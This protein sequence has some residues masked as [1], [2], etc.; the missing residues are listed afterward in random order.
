M[1]RGPYHASYQDPFRGLAVSAVTSNLIDTRAAF[2]VSLSW[3]TTSGS[4]SVNT[5]QISNAS[6]FNMSIPETTWSDWTVFGDGSIPATQPSGVSTF[7]PPLGYRFAR[8]LK[9]LSGAS[10][11]INV[12]ILYR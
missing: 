2:D 6:G 9:E 5:Y 8:I 11:E 1:S 3:R 10:F 7:E 4:S 12:N